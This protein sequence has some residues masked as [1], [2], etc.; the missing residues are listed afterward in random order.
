MAQPLTSK[1]YSQSLMSWV[2]NKLNELIGTDDFAPL[3]LSLDDVDLQ[4]YCFDLLGSTESSHSFVNELIGKRNHEHRTQTQTAAQTQNQNTPNR[5]GKSNRKNDGNTMTLDSDQFS[6][7]G[8]KSKQKHSKPGSAT[9]SSSSASGVYRQA[10]SMTITHVPV[11]K[12]SGKSGGKKQKRQRKA[13]GCQATLHD[14]FKNC[15]Q[16]GN[17]LCMVEGEG[18]CFHCSAFVT[19]AGSI[20]SIAQSESGLEY[21][22]TSEYERAVAQKDKLLRFGR[23]KIQQTVI[24]DDQGD[25]YESE[26]NNLWLSERERELAA[27]K[28]KQEHDRL[29]A[30]RADRTVEISINFGAGDRV[31]IG[32]V[33][34][35]RKQYVFDS[36]DREA[37][38]REKQKQSLQETQSQ[39]QSQSQ[40][41]QSQGLS[42][43]HNSSLTGHASQIYASLQKMMES[44]SKQK[45][46][47]GNKSGASSPKQEGDAQLLSSSGKSAENGAMTVL[48]D[49]FIDEA[50]SDDEDEDEDEKAEQTRAMQFI[51]RRAQN[52]NVRKKLQKRSK[53]RDSQDQGVCLSM[54]QPWASLLVLGIKKV[55]GR[56]WN[57]GYRGRLWIASARR[58][59][60]PF[61]IEE[62]E[63]QYC[64]V[65]GL[66]RDQIPFPKEYAT[67]ALLGCVDM[68]DCLSN[69]E[70]QQ[71]FIETGLSTEQNA[72][73]HCFLCENPRKLVLPGQISGD[74]KLWKMPRERIKPMQAGLAP[75][76]LSWL[77]DNDSLVIN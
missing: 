8:K 37:E 20:A 5:R 28:A 51:S 71:Q 25:F 61:E 44:E 36:V 24:I 54:H 34:D 56:S 16:C 43:Y 12:K 35:R 65:Y 18:P 6:F 11:V 21:Q 22:K 75:C 33:A 23:E 2:K 57:S 29:D 64:E 17:I 32:E 72:S 45:K 30:S 14:V 19:L 74:H 46:K 42:W 41:Q 77:P 10:G 62:V 50:N 73:A 40:S 55:E 69:Q 49:K 53:F 4:T 52:K 59:P 27:Q 48:K 38:R 66:P 26:A 3:I 67:T 13:C 47:V 9:T 15:T 76:D 39:S 70:Y 60:T 68:V 31:A 7:T 1:H 58:E 63:Q